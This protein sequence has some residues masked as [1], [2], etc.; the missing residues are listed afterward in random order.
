MDPH[1]DHAQITDVLIRYATGIDQ[2]DWP[3]FR[4]CF[5]L[6]VDADYD[7]IGAFAGVDAL[8]SVMEKAHGAM[9]PTFHRITNVV[10]DVDGDHATARSYVH[11]VLIVSKED[12]DNWVDV[13]GSYDD[14][15]VRT[16]D[17]WRIS[18]RA[19]RTARML[20]SDQA[21]TAAS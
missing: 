15:F 10:I 7:S 18:R 4:T 12:R 21:S 8:T 19:S 2:R 1:D 16:D 6:D 5:T 11:A 9:G 14:T 13:V 17:G 3:L 20:R